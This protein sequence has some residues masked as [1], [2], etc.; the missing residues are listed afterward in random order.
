MI[1]SGK[2][3]KRDFNA[4]GIQEKTTPYKVI[5]SKHIENNYWTLAQKKD[6]YLITPFVLRTLCKNRTC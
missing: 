1:Y 6:C 5:Y 2:F 4:M 3:F